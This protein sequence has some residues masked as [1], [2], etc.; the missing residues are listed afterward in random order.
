MPLRGLP[1]NQASPMNAVHYFVM[2][3][4]PEAESTR[5]TLSDLQIYSLRRDGEMRLCKSTKHLPLELSLA[6]V[7]DVSVA[8]SVLDHLPIA[9]DKTYSLPSTLRMPSFSV[10]FHLFLTRATLS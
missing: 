2:N 9:E 10:H 1:S 8:K 4:Q 5:F 7:E 6:L 3:M